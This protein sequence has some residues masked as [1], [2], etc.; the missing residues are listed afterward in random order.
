MKNRKIVINTTLCYCTINQ[1][2]LT[3]VWLLKIFLFLLEPMGTSF[4]PSGAG[5]NLSLIFFTRVCLQEVFFKNFG[6]VLTLSVHSSYP[7]WTWGWERRGDLSDLMGKIFCR[8]S[9]DKCVNT[10]SDTHIHRKNK[11]TKYDP[12]TVC[13]SPFRRT[14]LLSMHNRI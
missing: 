14:R 4:A 6:H 7:N 3:L 11:D 1:L 5:I 9:T 13:G 2:L 10:K 8:L 12:C